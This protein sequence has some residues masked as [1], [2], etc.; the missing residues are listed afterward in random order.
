M[1]RLVYS[2]EPHWLDVYGDVRVQVRPFTSG[3]LAAARTEVDLLLPEAG[4]AERFVALS[5]AMARIAIIAW[6][7][8]GDINDNP[9]PVSIEAVTA[10]MDIW[11]IN[12]AFNK[13]YLT[14]GLMMAVEKKG[15]APLLNG[16]LEGAR[17]T[18]QVAQPSA[19]IAPI[20]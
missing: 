3:L 16:T 1:L 9:L 2:S 5:S 12:E 14:P 19:K 18:A 15:F 10:L 6:E 4:A 20:N 7:G 13:A 8:V 17:D 11:V